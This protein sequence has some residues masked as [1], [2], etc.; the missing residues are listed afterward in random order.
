MTNLIEKEWKE[1]ALDC[2]W[3]YKDKGGQSICNGK[4]HDGIKYECSIKNCA[5]YHFLKSTSKNG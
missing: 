2:P 3:R 4:S 1:I 5:I